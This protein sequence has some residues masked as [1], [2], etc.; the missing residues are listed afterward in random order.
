MSNETS[1]TKNEVK[2]TNR[3]LRNVFWRSNVFQGSWNFERMQALGFA[4]SMTPAIRRLYPEGSQERIDAM[5]RHNE[6][7]NTQPFVAAPVI[8]VTLAMEEKRANGAD[9]DDAAING[10][11]VGLMGP[12]AGVG[13]PI[14]WGTLRPIFAALGASI[15]AS[16]SILGPILFFVLWNACRLGFRWWGIFYGYRKG[17][18]VVSDM[19]GN[20]LQKLTEGASILGLFIMGALVNRWTTIN[21]PLV[22]S[23]VENPDTGEMTV[24]T[25]QSVLDQLMPGLLP[26]GA[27]FICMWLLKKKVNA[28]W[29]IFGIFVIGILGYWAGILA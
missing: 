7:F 3:D 28:L 24:T 20:L 1:A 6:F 18:D 21:V 17:V 19:G 12:L 9:I 25:V 29:I 26:L 4:F 16:G 23:E 10:I 14:F 27:T 2:L 5:K 15:A 13:D 22:L 8:G 11:K